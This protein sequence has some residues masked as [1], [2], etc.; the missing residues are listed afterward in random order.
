MFL[1]TL[2]ALKWYDASV[3]Y[4]YFGRTRREIEIKSLESA[5]PRSNTDRAR[6]ILHESPFKKKLTTIA[7]PVVRTHRMGGRNRHVTN[8]DTDFREG[9]VQFGLLLKSVDPMLFSVLK[10]YF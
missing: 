10:I 2:E 3:A 7:R 1:K 5:L 4:G 8:F 6:S 9:C